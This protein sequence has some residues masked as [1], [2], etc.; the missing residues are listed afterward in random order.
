[1]YSVVHQRLKG[2]P[3][4]TQELIKRAQTPYHIEDGDH[5]NVPPKGS[6]I[7]D[8]AACPMQSLCNQHCLK[9]GAK[10]SFTVLSEGQQNKSSPLIDVRYMVRATIKSLIHSHP[11]PMTN[12][13]AL[14]I[15]NR[16]RCSKEN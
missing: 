8:L 9:E 4:I 5:P 10:N 13:P 14:F 1:M 15:R 6:D 3:I 12:E 11:H 2:Q 16:V 7:S